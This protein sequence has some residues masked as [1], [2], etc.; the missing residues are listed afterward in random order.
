MLSDLVSESLIGPFLLQHQVGLWVAVYRADPGYF[1]RTRIDYRRPCSSCH[2]VCE[3]TRC[4]SKNMHHFCL[5]EVS[6]PCHQNGSAVVP[7][8]PV[9]VFPKPPHPAGESNWR[10]RLPWLTLAARQAGKWV[11]TLTWEGGTHGANRRR[12]VTGRWAATQQVSAGHLVHVLIFP[13]PYHSMFRRG[14]N[15]SCGLI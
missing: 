11:P 12:V 6:P 1:G 10:S 4:H 5:S 15:I 13:G 2:L 3:G 7:L 9:T 8:S 14:K